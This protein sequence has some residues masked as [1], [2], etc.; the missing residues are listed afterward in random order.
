VHLN[1]N[2]P[3]KEAYISNW[4]NS[5]EMYRLR[6]QFPPYLSTRMGDTISSRRPTEGSRHS[7]LETLAQAVAGDR[8]QHLAQDVAVGCRLAQRR[9]A[10]F[11]PDAGKGP[12]RYQCAAAAGS[13]PPAPSRYG[14][15]PLFLRIKSAP[16]N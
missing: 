13:R 15:L 3:R 16:S 4:L 11:A 9:F 6:R 1:F 8:L 12:R 5:L 10:V 2:L 14:S 7:W